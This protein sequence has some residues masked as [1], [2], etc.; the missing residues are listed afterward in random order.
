MDTSSGVQARGGAGVEH[1]RVERPV[2]AGWALTTAVK[3]LA[4][5]VDIIEHA[6]HALV[7]QRDLRVQQAHV[8]PAADQRPDGF[9]AAVGRRGI[10]AGR[11]IHVGR[12]GPAFAED[13]PA[14]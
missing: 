4:G 3:N 6:G 13:A 2:V 7:Q 8:R 11:P 12:P 14:N 1:G 5:L 10:E 9:D